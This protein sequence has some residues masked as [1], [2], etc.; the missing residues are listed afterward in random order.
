MILVAQTKTNSMG[1]TFLEAILCIHCA[2]REWAVT[3]K[4]K[5]VT[6][7]SSNCQE[8]EWG[9]QKES[10]GKW[11]SVKEVNDNDVLDL[12]RWTKE[13][14]GWEDT[15]QKNPLKLYCHTETV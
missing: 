11:D 10:K 4:M 7:A 15:K 9:K 6:N 12:L 14:Q 5:K 2:S 3:A 1:W 8:S 13:Q